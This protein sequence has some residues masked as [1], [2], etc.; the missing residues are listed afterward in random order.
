MLGKDTKFQSER[1]RTLLQQV[2]WISCLPSFP[3]PLK[4]HEKMQRGPS[5]CCTTV[6]LC[7]SWGIPLWAWG[8]HLFS[9]KSVSIPEGDLNLIAW[10]CLLQGCSLQHN[11]EKWPRKRVIMV[12]Q[13]WHSQQEHTGT[14]RDHGRLLLLTKPAEFYSTLKFPTCWTRQQHSVEHILRKLISICSH[15]WTPCGG[16]GS[17]SFILGS[18]MGFKKYFLIA[19]I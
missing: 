11:Y 1:Q 8:V 6:D 4:A 19:S 7:H 14:P 15:F 9:S 10:G 3:L 12:L 13:C 17:E 2:A 18:S 5:G 16:S